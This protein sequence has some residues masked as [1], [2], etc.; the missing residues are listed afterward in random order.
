VPQR[1]KLFLTFSFLCVSPLL[2]L[3]LISFKSA[4]QNTE[5]L[6]RHSLNDELAVTA[7]TFQNVLGEREHE[8]RALASGPV[9][10]YVSVATNP[11]AGPVES[12]L[13]G[14]VSEAGRT[15]RNAVL[16][17]PLAD[18]YYA[19]LAC[20]GSDHQPLFVVEPGTAQAALSWR[21]KDFLPGQ[22]EPD[23]SVW[24]AAENTF[25]CS[26]VRD[27][28]FGQVNRC[29]FPVP[30]PDNAA[31]PHGSLVAD[32]RLDSLFAAAVRGWE[33]AADWSPNAHLILVTDASGKII[34]H[35]NVALKHQ[36]LSA[37]MPYFSPAAASM[38]EGQVGSTF[39]VSEAGDKWLEAHLQLR[40]VGVSLAVARNYSLASRDARRAGWLEIVLSI[41]LGF[42]AAAFLT[43]YFQ[44]KTQ[45]IER[46]TES[47]AAIAG[48][49]L[50]QRVEARSSDDMRL[51]ADSVNLMTERLREQLA[52]E[53][54]TR[55]FESFVRL[56][57]ILTHD[58]KNAIEGLSLMVGNMERHFD[59][60]A[61]RVDAMKSLTA[62]TN[63]LRALVTR[64][65]R[66][67]NT[68]SG[69][70][71][72]PQP[73][74]L[75]PIIKR[76]L[77]QTAEPLRDRYQI[78]VQLP[79]SLFALVEAERFDEVVENLVLNALE[80]MARD[81]GTLRVVGGSAGD[82]KVFCSVTDT[83]VGIS[84]EFIKRRL[85]R[86]FATQKSKGVGLGLY[87]CREVV[88][89]SGGTI[90]VESIE[91]SGATF[92]VVLASAQFGRK[93]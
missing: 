26:L 63:K 9:G 20:F 23:Q 49:D 32:L 87:T 17:L 14:P 73:T 81:G 16:A 24:H 18:G 43:V 40:P 6:V 56:S 22:L 89:A 46:V 41:L 27:P 64:L 90:E 67:V 83:G 10:R 34:Y 76:V 44:R 86:P 4:Q 91:G 82:G 8:L 88:R 11:A 21:T 80:A 42:G 65:S 48:G 3:S 30:A 50:E 52:R 53:A 58:L 45:R 57:A 54:E 1:K 38:A 5:E 77:A 68:L 93:K 39:Y 79:L 36:L 61:F 15:A 85:F 25:S 13:S 29:S 60:P 71:K 92:R 84:E 51:L 62:A 47:V 78:E 66:P 74:D 12:N 37:A 33:P 72:M 75:V 31:K 69:E 7:T 2:I 28:T 70:F 19:G 59:N 35:T 55:Q